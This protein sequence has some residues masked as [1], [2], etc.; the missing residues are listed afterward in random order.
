MKA[1]REKVA[2]YD[3]LGQGLVDKL[4]FALFG[5]I[6]PPHD[7]SDHPRW[8]TFSKFVPSLWVRPRSLKGLAAMI[9]PTDWSQTVVFDELFLDGNYDLTNLGFV[10]EVIL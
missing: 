3:D 4:V 2:K 7:R 1:L 5:L 9:Q 10:P 8:Q 6:C